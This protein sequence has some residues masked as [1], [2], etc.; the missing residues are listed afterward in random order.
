[1]EKHRIY[2]L[3]QNEK[4][5]TLDIVGK[6]ELNK[7]LDDAENRKIYQDLDKIWLASQPNLGPNTDESWMRLK[8]L[9]EQNS[10][11]NKTSWYQNRKVWKYAAAAAVVLGVFS[12]LFPFFIGNSTSYQTASG[13]ILR[14]KLPDGTQVILSQNTSIAYEE[15]GSN[16]NLKLNGEA[17]F[18][19]AK[20][21]SKPF[22]IEGPHSFVKI[23]GTKFHL[24]D[25]TEETS[26][27]LEVNEG[28]VEFGVKNKAAKIVVG[29]EKVL[30]NKGKLVV[31]PLAKE[32]NETS[33]AKGETAFNEARLEEVIIRLQLKYGVQIVADN[34]ALLNCTFSGVFIEESPEEA[35]RILCKTLG[36]SSEQVN[37]VYHLN[38]NSCGYE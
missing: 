15:I 11:R 18:D 13:E 20:N 17:Y 38:G 36:F 3:H 22:T 27:L 34:P 35:I 21:A 33:F 23:L 9:I 24:L 10:E 26:V 32:F 6:E 1:M 4:E 19:I 8:A 16:R 12:F 7:L 31:T 2:L 5:G 14:V 25:Q 30:I 37:K 28:R 29:G